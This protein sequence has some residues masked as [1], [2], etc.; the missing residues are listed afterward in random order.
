M[1]FVKLR[2]IAE[3]QTIIASGFNSITYNKPFKMYELEVAVCLK[4]QSAP[5]PDRVRYEMLRHLSH[6]SL[7]HL[8]SFF[9]FLWEA[10]AFPRSWRCAH[11]I[12]LLKPG[13]DPSLATSYRPITLTSC[14]GKT[15]ER[16]INRRLMFF[17]EEKNFFDINQCGFRAGQSTLD[18]L[19]RLESVVRE[20]FVHRQHCVSMFFY[21]QKA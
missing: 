16:L 3:K 2:S 14:L 1:E 17:L 11:V 18:H 4:K 8:L 7:C 20:V 9:N 19:V 15:Y 12:P 10:A 21:L 13:K 5:G 6:G